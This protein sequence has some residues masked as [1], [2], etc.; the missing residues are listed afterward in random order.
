MD[1]ICVYPEDV[2]K[3]TGRKLRYAQ[4]LLQALKKE[5]KKNKN[6]MITKKE[7]ADRLGMEEDDIVLD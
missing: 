4:K 2:C 5:L 1:R 7:L 6:Q 3:I